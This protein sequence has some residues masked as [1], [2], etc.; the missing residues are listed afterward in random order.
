MIDYVSYMYKQFLPTVNSSNTSCIVFRC[1]LFNL[2]LPKANPTFYISNVYDSSSNQANVCWCILLSPI[3]SWVWLMTT[4]FS[5]C[6]TITPVR[7]IVASLSCALST[8]CMFASIFV[9][10]NDIMLPC[11]FLVKGGQPKNFGAYK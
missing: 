4:Y 6:F 9:V 2:C 3:L 11:S 10:N 8:N 5:F 1:Q 7:K